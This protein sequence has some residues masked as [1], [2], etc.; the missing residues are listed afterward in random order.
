MNGTS[1]PDWRRD[2]LNSIRDNPEFDAVVVGGGINGISAYRELALQGLRVLLVERSDFCSGCSA[3][4]SRMIHGGLRYLENGEFQ[5][6]RESLEE[7]DALLANAPHM[8]RP[9]AT[10]I[11][12]TS[13]FSGLLNGAIGFLTSKSRP[14]NRG[15]LV[16]KTGLT[17]YDLF[18]RKRRRLPTHQ[19]R[20]RARTL[21][22]WPRLTKNLKFSATYY[23]AWISHPERLGI[24][25]L[26]DCEAANPKSIAL[27]YAEFKRAGDGFKLTDQIDNT[28]LTISPG[29]IVNATGAWLDF[30]NA[31]L[32]PSQSA[33]NHRFVG[34]TK[35]SHLII[36]NKILF[37]ALD[38][39]MIYFENVDGRVCILFPY[40][41][42][43]L[44]GST[45]LR[46]DGAGPVRCEDD[47][48]DYI[49]ASLAQVF[50]D[51]AVAPDDIV[52]TF[53]GVRPLPYSEVGF[54]G[55]ISRDHYTAK[56]GGTPPVYCMIGGKWTT[57]RAFGEQAA[58]MVLVD[59]A[60]DRIVQTRRLAIGGGVDFTVM[61]SAEEITEIT[62]LASEFSVSRERAEHVLDHYGSKARDVLAFCASREDAPL[63]A[64]CP[65]SRGEIT[66]LIRRE[67]ALLPADIL[68][69]RTSLAIT[70]AISVHLI[71]V[72][73]RIMTKELGWDAATA[74]K[75]EA[76]FKDYLNTYHRVSE[77]MLTE[78]DRR[79]ACA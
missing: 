42:R 66:W 3:A 12:I 6:V 79:A 47:E 59:L 25:L 23:D 11:P 67:Y 78:R 9:L 2:K 18:T 29:T 60:R 62:G 33:G 68:L 22:R 19:M 10:T 57:F 28:E 52:Y 56:I 39:N 51:I 63:A 43:V 31:E 8:V 27:N 70:G 58:D 24:E 69:R 71:S 50:P 37:D 32:L 76:E 49:L 5:L 64:N 30:T 53:S 26:Q 21:A 73:C 44:L 40:L 7:R 61:N 46:V 15:A 17:L 20:S 74:R 36:D 75:N 45:D 38:G 35:G 48:L 1:M 77:T 16:I 13:V 55:R 54:T 14:T 34:G 4:P 65:I 72:V 41:G